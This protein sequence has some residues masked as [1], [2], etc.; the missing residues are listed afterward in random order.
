MYT[1][2]YCNTKYDLL[3]VIIRDVTTIYKK[4]ER[5]YFTILDIFSIKQNDLSYTQ[6]EKKNIHVRVRFIG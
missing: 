5:S 1:F 3:F 2:E 4:N 6:R